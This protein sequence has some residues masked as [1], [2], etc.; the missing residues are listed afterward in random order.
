M[1]GKDDMEFWLAF[2][3]SERVF[4]QLGGDSDLLVASLPAGASPAIIEKM[5]RLERFIEASGDAALIKDF[6]AFGSL[7]ANALLIPN[8]ELR[9]FGL[10][11][12]KWFI[13]EA[14]KGVH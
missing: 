13:G 11:G 7:I 2:E 5:A 6:H 14:P 1:S 3:L 12:D 9:V 4:D 8:H 10:D